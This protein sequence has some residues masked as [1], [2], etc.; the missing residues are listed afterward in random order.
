M[1]HGGVLKGSG[2]TG[3]S[4]K[5]AWAFVPPIPNELTP[6]QRGVE[7]DTQSHSLV[8]TRMGYFQDR[9]ADWERRNADWEQASGDEASAR[10]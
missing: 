7:G 9:F 1:F 5:T 10:L 3:A 8:F 4:S 2:I 6:A